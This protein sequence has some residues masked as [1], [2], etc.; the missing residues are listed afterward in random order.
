MTRCVGVRVV[1]FDIRDNEERLVC[2][3]GIS[4]GGYHTSVTHEYVIRLFQAT[5]RVRERTTMD[6][7]FQGMTAESPAERVAT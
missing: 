3:N 2:R 7:Y 4:D 5:E 1:I 6:E